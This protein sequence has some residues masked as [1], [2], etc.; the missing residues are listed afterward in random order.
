MKEEDLFTLFEIAI[1]DQTYQARHGLAR[2]YRIY[3]YALGPGQ[4]LDRFNHHIIGKR[5][6]RAVIVVE[7]DNNI[8]RNIGFNVKKLCSPLYYIIDLFCLEFLR[9]PHIDARNG[10]VGIGSPEAGKESPVGASA[11]A[12]A[13]DVVYV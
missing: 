6:A 5:I 2:I 11:S 13:D 12:G 8:P 3:K 7:A 1:P 4:Q 9:S 10:N